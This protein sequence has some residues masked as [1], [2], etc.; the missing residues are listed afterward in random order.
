MAQ[1]FYTNG[2]LLSLQTQKLMFQMNTAIFK[3]HCCVK[4][5]DMQ[6]PWVQWSY[7]RIRGITIQ[8]ASLNVT[9]SSYT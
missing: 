8:V 6:K 9:V 5:P 3:Q 1:T 2:N 4:Y 7:P